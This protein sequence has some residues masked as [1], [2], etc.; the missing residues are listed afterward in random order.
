MIPLRNFK[1]KEI[2]DLINFPQG[3]E[4]LVTTED[5]LNYPG[6][7]CSFYRQNYFLTIVEHRKVKFK[8]KPEYLSLYQFDA[9]IEILPWFVD[10]FDFFLK[11]ASQGGLPSGNI[12]TD[13]ELVGGYKYNRSRHGK[14]SILISGSY[15]FQGGFLDTWKTLANKY[16]NGTL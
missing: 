2:K 4:Y 13:K 12:A 15:M 7:F 11:P 5:T 1:L 9:P 3:V 10:K 8:D 6:R 14:Q 16:E